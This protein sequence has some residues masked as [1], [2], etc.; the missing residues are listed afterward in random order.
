MRIEICGG[1]GSGKTTLA[2]LLGSTG[3]LH[4][5]EDFKANPFWQP[6]YSNPDKFNFETEITFL[7]Q[8]YHEIKI[9]YEKS[10]TFVCDFSFY[11]D[12]AYAKMGLFFN[13]LKIFEEVFNE[14]LSELGQPDLL[15]C[16]RCD[17]DTL[18]KRVQNRGRRE[19]DS[20]NVEFL[21]TLS[22][23]IYVEANKLGHTNPVLYIDSR[24]Y[25][26]AFS[27]NDQREILNQINQAVANLKD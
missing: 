9:A 27:I 14:G 2:T 19:E 25:N 3:Y 24:K 20:I 7:L 6:F 16:L 21:T 15:I 1:I 23:D 26:F 8:H 10:N 17:A 18:L 12:L 13:R 22:K 5:L 4:V 11:Q